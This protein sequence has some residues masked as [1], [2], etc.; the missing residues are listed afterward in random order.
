MFIEKYIALRQNILSS[1]VYPFRD[2]SASANFKLFFV[3]KPKSI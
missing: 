2:A 3:I 1:A